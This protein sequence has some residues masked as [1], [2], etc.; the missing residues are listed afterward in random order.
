MTLP[1]A[2]A[3]V[4]SVGFSTRGTHCG[5][6]LRGALKSLQYAPAQVREGMD[7]IEA[8]GSALGCPTIDPAD[9]GPLDEV[10]R[11]HTG[12]LEFASAA[13]WPAAW[14]DARWVADEPPADAGEPVE[15]SP[16]DRVDWARESARFDREDRAFNAS[17]AGA[18]DELARDDGRVTDRDMA[19]CGAVG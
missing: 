9:Q 1:I 12:H 5:A 19:R 10:I 18:L 8:H 7:W 11:R 2:S 17:L 4:K 3:P 13:E 6:D 15:P 14:D 16:A